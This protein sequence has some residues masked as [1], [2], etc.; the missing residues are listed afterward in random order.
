MRIVEKICGIRVLF[1]VATCVCFTGALT[2]AGHEVRADD[3]LPSAESLLDR[4]VEATGGVAKQEA[5]KSMV[6]TGTFDNDIGGHT[7]QTDI[8]LTSV[9]PN[10]QHMA[11]HHPQF[12][13]VR[14]TNGSRAW[15]WRA[16]EVQHAN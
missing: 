9:A 15:E 8:T 7:F 2:G 12:N 11:L 13:L 3:D 5:I 10:Q 14:V 4:H 6:L 16:S 1:L